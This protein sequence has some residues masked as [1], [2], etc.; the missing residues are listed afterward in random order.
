MTGG[1][2]LIVTWWVVVSTLLIGWSAG[3]PE[4]N[5]LEELANEAAEK[6]RIRLRDIENERESAKFG[7]YGRR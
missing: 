2:I 4:R 5:R 1:E 3:I 7:R 6:E